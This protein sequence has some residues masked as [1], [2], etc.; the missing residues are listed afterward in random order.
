VVGLNVKDIFTKWHYNFWAI[1]SVSLDSHIIQ[2]QAGKNYS[3]KGSST[4]KLWQK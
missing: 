4:M 3:K 2:L 1:V